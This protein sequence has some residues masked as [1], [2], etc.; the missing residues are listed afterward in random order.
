MSQ[1]SKYPEKKF[2]VNKI[3]TAIWR[4]QHNKNGQS[5]NRFS[6]KLQKSYRDSNTGQW[7]TQEI[8]LFPAEIPAV[9]AVCQRAYEHCMV[10]E[11]SEEKSRT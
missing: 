11:H 4:T 1:E 5:R 3:T 10:D 9:Q 2:K 7:K 8:V 6:I